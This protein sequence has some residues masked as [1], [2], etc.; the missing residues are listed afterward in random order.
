MLNFDGTTRDA[1]VTCEWIFTFGLR[2]HLSVVYVSGESRLLVAGQ[3]VGL[4]LRQD[5]L[6]VPVLERLP[7]VPWA[8]LQNVQTN[9]S[10]QG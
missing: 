4:N 7:C 2:L 8:N 9:W 1:D 10:K 3:A 6:H 5:A